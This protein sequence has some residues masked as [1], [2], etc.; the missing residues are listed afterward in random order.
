MKEKYSVEKINL[1]LDK[2][3]FDKNEVVRNYII[4]DLEHKGAVKFI[5]LLCDYVDNDCKAV[6]ESRD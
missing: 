2:V 1:L 5:Q 4:K 3:G 6:N